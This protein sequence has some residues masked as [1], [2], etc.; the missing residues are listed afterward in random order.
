MTQWLEQLDP[1][2][3]LIGALAGLLV[4]VIAAWLAWRKGSNSE[5]V[6]QA[7][8]V[9]ALQ[10]DLAERDQALSAADR[11]LAVVQARMEEQQAHFQRERAGLEEAEKR[12]NES[13]ERLAGKVFDERSKRF[14]ELSE[15]QLGGL[16]KPLSKDLESFRTRVDETHSEE[17][18][19]HA[20]LRERLL[21][22]EG[23]NKQLNEEASNLTS[24]LRKS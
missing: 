5:A 13:F 16:L 12:L 1:V 24:R 2:S 4:A 8:A 17:L 21:H 22:L 18:K 3:L 6:R 23:L 10:A 7:Q 9:A 20:A 11:E 15:K 19:Q 14:T